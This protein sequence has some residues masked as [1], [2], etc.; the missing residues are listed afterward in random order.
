ICIDGDFELS[1]FADSNSMIPV[2]DN[3]HT[4]IEIPLS[5]E[6]VNKLKVGDIIS[7]FDIDG[8]LIIHRII[9]VGYDSKGWFAITKGDNNKINDGKIRKEQVR[10]VLV[11]IIY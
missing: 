6:D 3:G 10:C 8:N 5:Q 11:G 1:N 4:G 2:L 7:Y 9:E